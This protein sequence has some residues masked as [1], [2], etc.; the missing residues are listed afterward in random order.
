MNVDVP[1]YLYPCRLQWNTHRSTPRFGAKKEMRKGRSRS[2][3]SVE[4]ELHIGREICVRREQ[5]TEMI[6]T[7]ALALPTIF[8]APLCFHVERER[9]VLRLV[10]MKI[11][12]IRAN[13]L[14]KVV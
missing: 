13:H 4:T 14:C 3:C 7:R 2:F 6:A 10:V 5:R 1:A 11:G 9:S 12:R 8:E